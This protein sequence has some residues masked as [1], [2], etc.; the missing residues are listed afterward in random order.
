MIILEGEGYNR[1]FEKFRGI[2]E[3]AKNVFQKLWG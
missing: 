2:V 3:R 1:I